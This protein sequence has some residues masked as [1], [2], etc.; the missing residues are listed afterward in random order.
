M[1]EVV[2]W[3][4]LVGLLGGKQLFELVGLPIPD[5]WPR[6]MAT[7]GP[8]AIFVFMIFKEV[9]SQL[10]QSN[11]FDVTFEGKYLLTSR[12]VVPVPVM[13]VVRV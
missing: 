10:L 2:Q 1:V 13:V 6:N 5:F 9:N 4:L 8:T 11:A 12:A 7:M 3:F